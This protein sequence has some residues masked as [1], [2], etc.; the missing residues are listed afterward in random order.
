M[1]ERSVPWDNAGGGDGGPYTE[2]S[3]RRLMKAM[4]S[5]DSANIGVIGGYLN[6]LQPTG[7][8]A[9]QV[10]IATGAAIIDGTFYDNDAALALTGPT[11]VPMTR[12]VVGTTGKLLVLRKSWAAQTIRALVIA[13]ADGTSAIPAKVQTDLTTWDIPLMSFTHDTGGVIANTIDLREFTRPSP[14]NFPLSG[15]GAVLTTGVRPAIY[16]PKMTIVGW[17]L[18]SIG[19]V[20]GSCVIDVAHRAGLLNIPMPMAT[21]TIAGSEKPTLTTAQTAE[22]TNLTTWT[23]NIDAGWMA[24]NVESASILTD[25]TLALVGY[26]A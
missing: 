21:Y 11:H 5:A 15:A 1:V 20:N 2:D 19:G 17:K 12:P 25:V 7:S 3:F 10:S 22:D 8:G 13:S 26:R 16:V 18:M 9:D 23:R 14:V 4:F 6:S 24:L